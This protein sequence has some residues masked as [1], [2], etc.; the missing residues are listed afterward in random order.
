MV[1]MQ[2]TRDTEDFSKLFVS[3]RT[4][5]SAAESRGAAFS[6]SC[7]LRRR[8]ASPAGFATARELLA[9]VEKLEEE[10]GSRDAQ[11]DNSVQSLVDRHCRNWLSAKAETELRIRDSSTWMKKVVTDVYSIGGVRAC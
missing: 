5:E 9:R 11:F 7:R 3:S 1:S 2:R 6:Q 8:S 10:K 4:A